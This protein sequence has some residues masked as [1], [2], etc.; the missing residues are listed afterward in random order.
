M[1]AWYMKSRLSYRVATARNP[2]SLLIHRSAVLRCLQRSESKAEGRPPPRL[3][4]CARWRIWSA[5]SGIVAVIPRRRQCARM[6]LLE[7]A[8]SPNRCPGVVRGRPRPLR[9]IRIPAITAAKAVESCR[10][11]PVVTRDTGRARESP[12]STIF[13]LNPPRDRPRGNNLDRDLAGVLDG[14]L[15]IRPIPLYERA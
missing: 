11:P 15:V 8:L 3:P 1:V 2:L 14:I 4:R 12:A 10:C 13:V 6:A 7:N 5:F 9:Q